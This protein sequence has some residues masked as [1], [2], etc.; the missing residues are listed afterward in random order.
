MH[1][2]HR[3]DKCITM[4]TTAYDEVVSAGSCPKT[5]PTITSAVASTDTGLHPPALGLTGAHDSARQHCQLASPFRGGGQ[6]QRDSSA[7]SPSSF[8][9]SPPTRVRSGRKRRRRRHDDVV[10]PR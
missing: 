3:I 8:I 10:F 6:R 1:L 2:S 4:R 9:A 5:A 7:P